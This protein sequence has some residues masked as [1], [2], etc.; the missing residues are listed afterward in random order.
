MRFRVVQREVDAVFASLCT[1]L[2]WRASYDGCRL[3]LERT[4]KVGALIQARLAT[5]PKRRLLPPEHPY[6]ALVASQLS[7]L[8]ADGVAA[9]EIIHRWIAEAEERDRKDKATSTSFG[10]LGRYRAQNWYGY[11]VSRQ[12]EISYFRIVAIEI[13]SNSVASGRVVIDNAQAWRAARAGA[14]QPCRHVLRRWFRA[15]FSGPS[16]IVISPRSTISSGTGCWSTNG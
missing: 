15:I 16:A 7:Y 6:G 3:N 4:R 5:D 13:F 8:K 14:L 9:M 2:R 12:A 11:I 10:W 1:Q